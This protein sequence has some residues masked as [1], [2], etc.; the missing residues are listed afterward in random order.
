[1]TISPL[2]LLTTAKKPSKS[3][4]SLTLVE[5]YDNLASWVAG[6]VIFPLRRF[7]NQLWVLYT[8]IHTISVLLI[9]A[10]PSPSTLPINS[11][12]FR[13]LHHHLPPIHPHYRQIGPRNLHT[14]PREKMK[15]Q[16]PPRVSAFRPE[17]IVRH[18]SAEYNV[19]RSKSFD[20]RNCSGSPHS[21]NHYWFQL[22]TYFPG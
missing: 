3:S 14:L 20:A 6:Q 21:S 22:S 4:R 10:V 8:L 18:F 12:P 5:R 11:S 1:M 15:D 9:N 7:K 13:L 2:D 19:E 17:D 16:T